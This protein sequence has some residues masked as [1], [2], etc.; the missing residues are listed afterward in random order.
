[1]W[2]WLN[3]NEEGLARW[4]RG[5]FLA[6]QQHFF[7]F[8][9]FLI[10]FSWCHFQS[11]GVNVHLCVVCVCVC[12]HMW[13]PSVNASIDWTTSFVS[14]FFFSGAARFFVTDFW[15][16]CLL[17]SDHSAAPSKLHRTCQDGTFAQEK[18]QLR[19]ITEKS[20]VTFLSHVAD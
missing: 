9:Y 7:L 11:Q 18:K 14:N 3:G 5:N 17:W 20:T 12:P 13:R 15:L 2:R 1:M 16:C 19:H 4:K 6:G 10:I 8:I